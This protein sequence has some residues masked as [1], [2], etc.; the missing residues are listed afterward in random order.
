ME[1]T[2]NFFPLVISEAFENFFLCL[3]FFYELSTNFRLVWCS[4]NKKKLFLKQNRQAE[5]FL[6]KKKY[7]HRRL[8]LRDNNMTIII[9]SL[10]H[11]SIENLHKIKQDI[12]LF[13]FCYKRQQLIW[14]GIKNSPGIII[15]IINK[16]FFRWWWRC[17]WMRK[18]AR[19]NEALNKD[20][21]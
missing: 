9:I 20:I 17:E 21:K 19:R 15:A 6:K 14:S 5:K 7:V 1:V 13:F 8:L 16:A 3:L 12:I 2:K 18:Y 11:P 10:W 4:N